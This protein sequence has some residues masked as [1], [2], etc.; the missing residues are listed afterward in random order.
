MARTS[1]W[2]NVM[3]EDLKMVMAATQTEKLNED[4]IELVARRYLPTNVLRYVVM[5]LILKN[6]SA[7]MEIK[8]TGMAEVQPVKSNND[9]NVKEEL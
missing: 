6:M 9:L 5:D 4:T 7:M 2:G 1:D 8:K 3:M